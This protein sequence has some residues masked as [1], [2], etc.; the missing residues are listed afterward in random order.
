MLRYV[1]LSLLAAVS[2]LGCATPE[3]VV[4]LEGEDGRVGELAVEKNGKTVVLDEAHTSAS[5]G[6]LGG[7][8]KH[9]AD[10]T[11]V[12]ETFAAALAARPKKP[13]SFVLYFEEGTTELVAGS[14]TELDAMFAE[15][16]NRQAPDVQVTGHTD[17]VGKISD[18]DYLAYQRASAV[19]DLLIGLG[20][21]ADTVTAVGR[22]ERELLVPTEDEVEEP[23]NRRVEVTVR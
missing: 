15:I 12:D 10:M 11:A 8:S 22:G 9:D 14:R 18:N 19:R 23:K 5:V 7:L 20:L 1:A 16:G 21:S 6:G 3:L 17:R 4:L 2:L 13:T